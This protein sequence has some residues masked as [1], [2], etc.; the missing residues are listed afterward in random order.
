MAK[1]VRIK[2]A[3]YSWYANRIGEV[4]EVEQF[5]ASA[6]ITLDDK[7]CFD[8]DD[9]EDVHEI[10]GVLY[11]EVARKAKVGEKVIVVDADKVFSYGSYTNGDVFTMTR[12]SHNDRLLIEVDGTF[13]D[14]S[15]LNLSDDEYR[16][17]EPIIPPPS[18]STDD[19]L[20]I[21]ANLTRRVYDLERENK[22]LRDDVTE[23]LGTITD[24]VRKRDRRIDKMDDKV[25]VLI[26]SIER[27][28]E[29]WKCANDTHS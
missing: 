26:G 22:K 8:I 25:K 5:G 9:C 3:S 18:T 16:V 19:L 24:L 4:F 20:E 2:K 29:E 28:L 7:Y 12:D 14:G 1:K 15:E 6:Y 11:K 13:H 27:L 10:D 21:T 23:T 17:L